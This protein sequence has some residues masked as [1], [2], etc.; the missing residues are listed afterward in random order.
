MLP[1]GGRCAASPRATTA[2][3]VQ[4]EREHRQRH[5]DPADP[6]GA[7][8][9]RGAVVVRLDRCDGALAVRRRGADAGQL[10]RLDRRPGRA[11]DGRGE[12]NASSAA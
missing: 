5:R 9:P 7:R 10:A 6:V 3:E 12:P 2:R 4:Q 1:H 11:G 8:E